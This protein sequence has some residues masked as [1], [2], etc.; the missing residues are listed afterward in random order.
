M[1]SLINCLFISL[2]FF[3][4]N[5]IVHSFQNNKEEPIYI[6][7]IPIS[8]YDF[9]YDFA[10]ESQ[11]EYSIKNDANQETKNQSNAV[12]TAYDL[13]FDGDFGCSFEFLF[14]E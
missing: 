14:Q 9:D 2:L 5:C 13:D 11:F 10:N 1:Y 12:E 3:N 4:I 8:D 7:G 6:N